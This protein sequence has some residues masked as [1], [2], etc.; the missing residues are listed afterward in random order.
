MRRRNLQLQPTSPGN[1]FTP[2]GSGRVASVV[3]PP[4]RLSDA[5]HACS[6]RTASIPSRSTFPRLAFSVDKE[7]LPLKSSVQACPSCGLDFDELREKKRQSTSQL[8]GIA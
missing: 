6:N 7:S 1:L 4:I 2:R 8:S 3:L 5:R